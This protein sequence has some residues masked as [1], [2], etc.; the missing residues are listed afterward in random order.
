MQ[1]S[2]AN[3]IRLMIFFSLLKK[4]DTGSLAANRRAGRRLGDPGDSFH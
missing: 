4:F 3:T 2:K 1:R